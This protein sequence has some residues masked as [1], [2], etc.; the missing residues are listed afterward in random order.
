MAVSKVYMHDTINTGDTLHS[1]HSYNYSVHVT[2]CIYLAIYW[3][4]ESLAICPKYCLW[5]ILYWRFSFCGSSK[6]SSLHVPLVGM[7]LI[8]EGV[9]KFGEYYICN[10][11]LKMPIVN[12]NSSPINHLV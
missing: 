7:P 2:T 11:F 9:I 4:E 3:R 12:L 10:F 5:Q 8:I 6:E 1:I